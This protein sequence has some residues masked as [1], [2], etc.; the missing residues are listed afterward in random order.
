[1]KPKIPDELLDLCYWIRENTERDARIIVP[2]AM[3]GVRYF[4][5]R[6]ILGN[7]KY[8]SFDIMSWY[9][10]MNDLSNGRLSSE[11]QRL[12][13]INNPSRTSHVTRVIK[14]GYLTLGA[15]EMLKLGEKY[16]CSHAVT[17]R[18][19]ELELEKVYRNRMYNIYRLND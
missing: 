1:V 5:E 3:Q 9:Q 12:V 16:E 10:R 11:R 13:S 7:F 18:A 4:G 17:E 8:L 2:P 15:E 14:G 6:A 19:H